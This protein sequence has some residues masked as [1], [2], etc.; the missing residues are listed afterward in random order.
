[1]HRLLLNVLLLEWVAAKV[2]PMKMRLRVRDSGGCKHCSPF[3]NSDFHL[4]FFK[5]LEE[6]VAVVGRIFV[7]CPPI[8]THGIG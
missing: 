7:Y 1:M 3:P 6:K 8:V 5:E 2:E 4:W